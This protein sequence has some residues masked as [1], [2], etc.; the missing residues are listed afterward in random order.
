MPKYGTPLWDYRVAVCVPGSW[1]CPM[2]PEGASG[3]RLEGRCCHGNSVDWGW[4]HRGGV[5]AA[6]QSAPRTVHCVNWNNS[7][8]ETYIKGKVTIRPGF[9]ESFRKCVRAKKW[10]Y[11][12]QRRLFLDIRWKTQG[13]KTKTQAKKPQ[14]SMIF[15]QNSKFRQIFQKFKKVFNQI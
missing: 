4:R 5:T 10:L 14:N 15:G 7:V 8:V 3:P 1:A 2:T 13:E 6:G 9:G 11:N 12:N